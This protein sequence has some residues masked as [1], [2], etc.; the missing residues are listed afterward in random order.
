MLKNFL[1]KQ[2]F[3]L[4]GV[5]ALVSPI[6]Y[7]KIEEVGGT[8]YTVSYSTSQ[9]ISGDELLTKSSLRFELEHILIVPIYD[10]EV[11][12]NANRT[13]AS[14]AFPHWNYSPRPQI[15]ITGASNEG[16]SDSMTFLSENTS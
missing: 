15:R 6:E 12:F 16:D 13:S 11:I 3:I 1:F 10:E 4:F 2:I 8:G 9:P 14:V 7:Y 5:I